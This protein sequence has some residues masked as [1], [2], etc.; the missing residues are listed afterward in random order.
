ML[1]RINTEKDSQCKQTTDDKTPQVIAV[2][3]H[4]SEKVNHDIMPMLS[5]GMG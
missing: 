5:C 1:G 4:E 2:L 3:L